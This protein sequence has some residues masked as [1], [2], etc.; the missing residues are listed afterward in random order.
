MF[1]IKLDK[2]GFVIIFFNFVAIWRQ[3]ALERNNTMNFIAM[4]KEWKDVLNNKIVLHDHDW[5]EID[6]I[7]FDLDGTLID[8]TELIIDSFL[9][10]FDKFFP[11]EYNR[12]DVIPFVGPPLYDTFGKINPNNV[13]EMVETY[14][15]YNHEKHDELIKEYEGVKE[16]IETL[17]RHEYKLAV[18]T[19]KQKVTAIKGLEIMKL[20]PFFETVITVDDVTNFK[21][22]PEPL[23]KAIDAL[24]ST[25]EK[26]LM[27]GDSMHDIVGGKNARTKTAAVAWSIQGKETLLSYEP[28]LMLHNMR[29][30]L[31]ILNI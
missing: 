17:H 15:N 3:A 28:D 21:P 31:S 19:S 8:T 27:V 23:L 5:Q 22:H 24:K 2:R 11:G 12:E 26:S 4:L 20:S 6:T 30:L 10:T 29:D 13:E 9:Y 1:F 16:T 14:R 18:V 7:L 25:P